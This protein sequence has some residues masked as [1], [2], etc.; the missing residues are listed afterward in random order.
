MRR[1]INDFLYFVQI[2]VW[3]WDWDRISPV[4]KI[5][6]L[7]Y[8]NWKSP[9]P[10][11]KASHLFCNWLFVCL[12]CCMVLTWT[13]QVAV[14]AVNNM[15]P[16]DVRIIRDKSEWKIEFE[17]FMVQQKIRRGIWIDSLYDKTEWKTGN[18]QRGSQ[19]SDPAQK[20]R[21]LRNGIQ[22]ITWPSIPK[23]HFFHDVCLVFNILHLLRCVPFPPHY[24]VI[25]HFRLNS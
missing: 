23:T 21:H 4:Q 22:G 5:H 25:Q 18:S 24:T 11:H 13:P 20:L 19:V 7:N 8:S 16:R 1:S 3:Y 9:Y 2:H 17:I 15:L 6:F 10:S 14:L 12:C